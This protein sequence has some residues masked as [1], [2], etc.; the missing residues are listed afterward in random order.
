MIQSIPE[1][2]TYLITM[3]P[4]FSIIICILYQF[5]IALYAIVCYL[6]DQYETERTIYKQ[7]E[8]YIEGFLFVYNH[9]SIELP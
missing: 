3:N 7:M 6:R 2:L 5:A 1:V 4:I 8:E 9:I